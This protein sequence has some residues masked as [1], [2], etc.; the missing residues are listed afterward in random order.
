MCHPKWDASHSR[1]GGDDIGDP[2]E[3]ERRSGVNETKRKDHEYVLNH[4]LGVG[5]NDNHE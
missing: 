2:S 4:L 1:W 3:G 5:D